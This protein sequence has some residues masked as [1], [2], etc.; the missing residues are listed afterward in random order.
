MEQIQCLKMYDISQILLDQV[1]SF[2]QPTFSLQ[3]SSICAYCWDSSVMGHEI[4][5]VAHL[6]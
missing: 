5:P 4:H 2:R 3:G 6:T 1:P